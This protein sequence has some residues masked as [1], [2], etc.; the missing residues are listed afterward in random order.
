MLD[1]LFIWFDRAEN[2]DRR[3]SDN[4]NGQFSNRTTKSI[5]QLKHM[6]ENA[7]NEK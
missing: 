3:R 6:R 4:G 7:R 5:R 2:I 1:V